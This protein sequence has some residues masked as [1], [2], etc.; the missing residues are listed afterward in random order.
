MGPVMSFQSFNKTFCIEE[1]MFKNYRNISLK[2][3]I[4][5][6]AKQSPNV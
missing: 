4:L 3:M 5:W 2:C 6:S 1:W